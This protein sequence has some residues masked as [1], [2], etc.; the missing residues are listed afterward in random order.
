MLIVS[1]AIWHKAVSPYGNRARAWSVISATSHHLSLWHHTRPRRCEPEMPVVCCQRTIEKDD[2]ER[3]IS[4]Q[5]EHGNG[6]V[7]GCRSRA[8]RPWFRNRALP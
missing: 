3:R 8:Q 1:E 4:G 6:R 7:A 2:H 5:C